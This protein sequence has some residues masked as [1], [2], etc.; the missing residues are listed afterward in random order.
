[1]KLFNIKLANIDGNT[2][3]T[4]HNSKTYLNKSL[5]TVNAFKTDGAIG[6]SIDEIPK[7]RNS[8]YEN[9]NECI[10]FS[11]VEVPDLF[12]LK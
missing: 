9:L 4:I 3:K 8:D 1:M 11:A 6:N 7:C 10:S 12:V 2:L 5:K